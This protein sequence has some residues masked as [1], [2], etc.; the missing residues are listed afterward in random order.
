[1]GETVGGDGRDG[2]RS[3]TG[4]SYSHIPGDHGRLLLIPGSYSH[5][6]D[7]IHD[8]ERGDS[9][10]DGARRVH[11][12]QEII[13]FYFHNNVKSVDGDGE[14]YIGIRPAPIPHNSSG[15]VR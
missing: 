7:S 2:Y 3:H 8:N 1:M 12:P 9:R 11:M 10:G 15:I 6:D 4:H 13:H 5:L 14:V